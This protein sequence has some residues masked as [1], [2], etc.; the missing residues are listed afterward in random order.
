MALGELEIHIDG[1][2]TPVYRPHRDVMIQV[3]GEAISFDR[4]AMS[5][6]ISGMEGEPAAIVSILHHDYEGALPN[7]AGVKGLRLRAGNVQIGENSLLEDLF[8]RDAV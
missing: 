6:E 2:E 5:R 7:S 8:P 4:L 3:V 1:S